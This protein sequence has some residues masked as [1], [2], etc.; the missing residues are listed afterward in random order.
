MSGISVKVKRG[1]RIDRAL[2]RLKKRMDREGVIQSVHD[3]RYYKTPSEKKKEM[4][5]SRRRRHR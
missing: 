5:N 2:R 3:K 4:M 1:E